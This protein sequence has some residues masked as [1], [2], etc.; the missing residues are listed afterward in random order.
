MNVEL[1]SQNFSCYVF[2]TK[3]QSRQVTREHS[4][5]KTPTIEINF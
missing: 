4:N 1:A 2:A 3:I 5:N